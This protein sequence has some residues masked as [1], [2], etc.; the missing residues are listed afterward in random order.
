[1][2]YQV[3]KVYKSQKIHDNDFVTLT[4]FY[5][6]NQDSA[7]DKI[8]SVWKNGLEAQ[9]VCDKLNRPVKTGGI[10]DKRKNGSL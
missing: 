7:T 10:Y 5:V 9:A 2:R 8:Q 1:M 3:W 4:E 6:I